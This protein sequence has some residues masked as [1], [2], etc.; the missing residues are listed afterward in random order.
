MERFLF[1]IFVPVF[2]AAIGFIILSMGLRQREITTELSAELQQPVFG[3]LEP[4]QKEDSSEIILLAVGDIMLDRGVEYIIKKHGKG[5]YEFPFLKMANYLQ[6]ADILF[7]NLE[8]V[9][10]DKGYK[11]GGVYSFRAEPEAIKGLK[12]AGF[13]VISVANNHVFDYGREAMEDNFERLKRAGIDFVGAGLSEKQAHSGI[14]KEV[15]GTK[16][17]FLAY[18]NLGSKHWQA[19][20]DFSGIAWLDERI[21]EDI[22]GAKENADLVIVSIHWGEEYQLQPSLEQKYFAHLAIDSGAD[23]VIGHHPHVVQP[24]EEYKQGWIV[25]SL[26]NFIFDQGFSQETMQ[27][28]LLEVLIEGAEIKKITQKRI[29]INKFFQPQVVDK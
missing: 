16:I 2:I 7:G 24:I 3:I 11:V 17:T 20:G 21:R 18:T 22:K 4:E 19:K 26:G 25:Y 8:S 9:I 10:S 6:K 27:G 23:L 29:K 13:D 15:K 5:D 12:Y 14:T 28:L 1:V